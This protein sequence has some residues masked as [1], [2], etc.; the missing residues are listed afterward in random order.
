[1]KISLFIANAVSVIFIINF[2]ISAPSITG[3]A[4]AFPKAELD[5]T[6]PLGLAVVFIFTTIALDIYSYV[7]SR[8]A[9]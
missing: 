2:L 3:F 8:N 5:V 1:M 9:V 6:S 4:V 7:K